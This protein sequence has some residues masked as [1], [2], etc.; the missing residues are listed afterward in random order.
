MTLHL[1]TIEP[2]TLHCHRPPIHETKA[3]LNALSKRR[4]AVLDFETA[5]ED[6]PMVIEAGLVGPAGEVLFESL[7]QPTITITPLVFGVHGITDEELVGAPTWPE[8][9][10]A[11]DE[12][13]RGNGIDFV[14]AYNAAFERMCLEYNAAAWGLP[15]LD[16]ELECLQELACGLLGYKPGTEWLSLRTACEQL[17]IER[18][19]S[20]RAVV[21]CKA[22]A[23]LGRA[24]QE[25]GRSTRMPQNRVASDPDRSF[26]WNRKILTYC[27]A[28]CARA[29]ASTPPPRATGLS[30]HSPASAVCRRPTSLGDFGR[31]SACRLTATS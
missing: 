17:G 27:A 10:A 3:R 29:T 6:H 20:H 24:L 23:S 12:V 14:L 31:R 15:V 26:H 22:T 1:P 21:D 8:V 5:S 19:A 9:Q 18:T 28:C 7:V 4:W 11:I 13:L 16:V 2:L 25:A 30:L